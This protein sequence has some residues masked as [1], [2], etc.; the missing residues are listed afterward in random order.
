MKKPKITLDMVLI[1]AIL[2]G[3][4]TWSLY[5]LLHTLSGDVLMSFGIVNNY[6][7]IGIILIV[8]G[9]LLVVIGKKKL[10]GVIVK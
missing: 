8:T 7:Q 6:W 1:M 3:L 4:F 9:A 10:R 5:N 2:A